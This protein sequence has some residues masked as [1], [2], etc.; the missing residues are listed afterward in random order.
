[1][2]SRIVSGHNHLRGTSTNSLGLHP[3]SATHPQSC[4]NKTNF[5]VTFMYSSWWPAILKRIEK[6]T[7]ENCVNVIIPFSIIACC[8][9][10]PSRYVMFQKRV[11]GKPKWGAQAVVRG[12]RFPCFPVATALCLGQDT[13]KGPFSSRVK[14]PPA[15]LSTTHGE[16]FTLSI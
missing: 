8:Q 15:H 5:C 3:C 7:N 1:M 4:V 6:T 11:L 16:S 2:F 12:A 14:L 10:S 13:A 9:N